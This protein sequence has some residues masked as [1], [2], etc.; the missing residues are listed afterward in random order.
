[1]DTQLDEIAINELTPLRKKVLE[2]LEHKIKGRDH[3]DFM[4]IFVSL[5]I[6]MN[7]FELILS[8]MVDYTE[9]HGM[10]VRILLIY[11]RGAHAI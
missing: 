1:M 2:E 7:N 5:F 8:D 4:E 6:L 11:Q 3:A 9:R 10:K